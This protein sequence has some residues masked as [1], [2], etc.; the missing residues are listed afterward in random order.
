MP[1]SVGAADVLG[2]ALA[3]AE[4]EVDADGAELAVADALGAALPEEAAELLADGA[5]L[6]ATDVA[7]ASGLAPVSPHPPR[8]PAARRPAARTKGTA[9]LTQRAEVLGARSDG[10]EGRRIGERTCSTTAV[11]SPG[12]AGIACEA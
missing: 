6:L 11:E 1:E 8:G 12:P 7:L 4:A 9:A 10:R 5:A 2:A 3:E